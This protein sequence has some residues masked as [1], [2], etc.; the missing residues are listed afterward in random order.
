[1]N[2]HKY[3]Q[4]YLLIVSGVILCFCSFFMSDNGE[5]SASVLGYFGECLIWVGSMYGMTEYVNY[6][7]RK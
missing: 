4:A 6:K 2:R 3:I 1:M 5:V 7:T